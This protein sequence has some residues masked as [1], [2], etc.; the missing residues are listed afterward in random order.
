MID[1]FRRVERLF[2]MGT[3][4][5]RASRGFGWSAGALLTALALG[6]GG[7]HMPD[8]SETKTE[9]KQETPIDWTDCGDGFQCANSPERI[10]RS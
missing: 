4:R 6:V 8:T 9:T 10:A 7:C 5:E 3:L 1:S 2:D